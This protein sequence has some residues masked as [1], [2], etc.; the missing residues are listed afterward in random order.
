[1]IAVWIEEFKRDW[2]RGKKEIKLKT[3]KGLNCVKSEIKCLAIFKTSFQRLESMP[4]TMFEVFKLSRFF[5]PL[6]PPP[7]CEILS[8]QKRGTFLIKITFLAHYNY[9]I[10]FKNKLDEINKILES[11]NQLH[12]EINDC[13]IT[14]TCIQEFV[15]AKKR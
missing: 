9:Y 2:Y 4:T 3:S 12:W 1:M 15:V 5:A 13:P 11:P 14:H 10:H 8:W 7:G 6:L